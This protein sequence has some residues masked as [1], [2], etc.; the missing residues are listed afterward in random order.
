MKQILQRIC[1]LQPE[2]SYKNN[3]A[4]QERSRLINHDL[5]N[6]IKLLEPVLSQSLGP[7]GG[8]FSVGS[9]DEIFYRTPRQ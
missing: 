2:Y 4:M 3:T 5:A 9:S 6:E 8:D 1:E 7:Y